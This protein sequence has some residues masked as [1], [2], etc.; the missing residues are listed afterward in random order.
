[1]PELRLLADFGQTLFPVALVR[2]RVG[3]HTPKFFD[4]FVQCKLRAARTQPG[5]Q[6]HMAT[7]I[8]RMKK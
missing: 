2:Q 7:T 6:L 5:T 1:M 8:L 4:H 3:V